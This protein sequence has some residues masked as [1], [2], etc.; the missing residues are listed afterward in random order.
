[1]STK[2][3]RLTSGTVRV[4]VLSG[5]LNEHGK[6]SGRTCAGCGATWTVARDPVTE[7]LHA[8]K[9]QVNADNAL[10]DWTGNNAAVECCLT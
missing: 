2:S 8:W 7:D 1:M 9:N 3:V 10:L 5:L 4:I 6:R